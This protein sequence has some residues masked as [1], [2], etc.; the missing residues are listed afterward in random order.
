MMLLY[1]GSRRLPRYS[2]IIYEYIL[3]MELVKKNK[4]AEKKKRGSI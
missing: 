2:N 1:L 4:R 3:P